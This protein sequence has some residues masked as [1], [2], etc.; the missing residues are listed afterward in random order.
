MYQERSHSLNP[1]I[2]AGPDTLQV[3]RFFMVWQAFLIAFNTQEGG[4]AYSSRVRWSN[5]EAVTTFSTADFLDIPVNGESITGICPIGSDILVYCD[6]STWLLRFTGDSTAPF[7]IDRISPEF[8]CAAPFSP[9]YTGGVCSAMSKLALI[10]SDGLSVKRIDQ[11]IPDFGLLNVNSAAAKTCYG[12]VLEDQRQVW[13]LYPS[14]GASSPDSVLIFNLTDASWGKLALAG[15]CFG[16]WDK[17]VDMT[18]DAFGDLT[19]DG[20][21][22]MTCDQ[23]SGSAG[24]PQALMGT[25][26][27]EVL[28]L[29]VSGSD[30]LAPISFSVTTGQWNPFNQKGK[31]ARLAFVEMLVDT[32]P[33]ATLDIDFYSDSLVMPYQSMTLSLAA[34]HPG[35]QK[36][37]IRLFSGMTGDCHQLKISN[38][39]IYPVAIHAMVPYF[40]PGGR[41]TL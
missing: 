34:E 35:Q 40:S 15:T 12:V 17:E 23:N 20:V 29:N 1:V 4:A 27:G 22:D 13:L 3:C 11:L 21:G 10:Q 30:L 37:W 32:D 2:G 24:Y 7:R 14:S 36:K 38:D 31:Q 33:D 26:T 16:F 5:A 25:M 18:T 28:N 41:L 8:G 6:K 9:V 19:T 39:D